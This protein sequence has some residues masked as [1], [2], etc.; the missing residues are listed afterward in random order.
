MSTTGTEQGTHVILDDERKPVLYDAKD[1][2]LYRPLGF[3]KK[4]DNDG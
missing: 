3:R 2:P 1:R 4:T